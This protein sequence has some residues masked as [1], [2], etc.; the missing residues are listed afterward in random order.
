[1]AETVN[2]P[3]LPMTQVVKFENGDGTTA[4]LLVADPGLN[5]GTLRTIYIRSDEDSDIYMDII[6]NDG[7]TDFDIARIRI[8]TRSGFQTA[9]GAA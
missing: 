8:P 4:K 9:G 6:M 1:M 7:S 2:F 5:G 3:A